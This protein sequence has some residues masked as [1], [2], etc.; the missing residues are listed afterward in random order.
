MAKDIKATA[1]EYKQTFDVLLITNSQ[2]NMPLAE[3]FAMLKPYGV[4]LALI[5]S[6][7]KPHV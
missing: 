1:E 3:Y 6:Y 2:D 7:Y 5:F 4:R